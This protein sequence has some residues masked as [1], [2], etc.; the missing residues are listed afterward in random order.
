MEYNNSYWYV[1][2]NKDDY[3][4]LLKRD[5]IEDAINYNEISINNI[6]N[7]YISGISSDLK[8]V[9]GTKIRLININDLKD[10]GFVDKTNTNYYE[11]IWEY[12][13]V[14]FR[15]LHLCTALLDYRFNHVP[16]HYWYSIW[17]TIV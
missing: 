1:I 17:R 4:T 6:L 12:Y 5:T 13:L 9:N 8:E 15:R 16:Y 3:V 10:L 7:S 2:S 11:N 14:Y